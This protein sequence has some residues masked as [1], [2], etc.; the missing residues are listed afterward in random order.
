[1]S[2]AEA[3]AQRESWVRGMTA[4][5]EHNRVDFEQ[6]PECREKA[7]QTIAERI[8]EP[9]GAVV[10]SEPSMWTRLSSDLE[11]EFPRL[12]VPNGREGT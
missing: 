8:A 9:S 1:M 2:P 4:R 3:A 6:C 7:R 12:F 5:C 11:R 10:Q